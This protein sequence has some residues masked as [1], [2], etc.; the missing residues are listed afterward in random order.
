VPGLSQQMEKLSE[1]ILIFFPTW[2]KSQTLI[3][4]GNPKVELCPD[5]T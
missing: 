2:F 5:K 3:V 1:P 4:P